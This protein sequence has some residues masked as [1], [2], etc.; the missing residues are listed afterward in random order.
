MELIKNHRDQLLQAREVP[1]VGAE[2]AGQLPHPFDGIEVGT[3][4]GQ[5]VEDKPVLMSSEERLEGG[6]VMVAPI[7]ENQDHAGAPA[8]LI[9]KLFEECLEGVGVEFFGQPRD[10][11]A[12]LDANRAEHARA[13]S[14]GRV[15]HYRV[16]VLGRDPH[17]ATR[18]VLLEMALVQKPEINAVRTGQ[19]REFFYMFPWLEG[20]PERSAGA[21]CAGG[22]PAGETTAGIGGRPWRHDSGA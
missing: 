17:P 20:R 6:G 12:L 22:S 19:L 18:A 3:V 4:G 14:S 8:M 9:K 5:E 1:V 10:Q 2:A 11:A 15:K 21:V 16:G 7:I 13:L